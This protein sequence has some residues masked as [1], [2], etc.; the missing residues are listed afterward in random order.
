MQT[1]TILDVWD[2]CVNKGQL[3]KGVILASL[4]FPDKDPSSIMKWSIEKRDAALFHIRKTLFGNQFTNLAHCPQCSQTVEWELSFQQLQIPSILE[5]PDN[6]EIAIDIPAYK[7]LVR[8]PNSNDLLIKDELQILYSCILNRDNYEDQNFETGLPDL[9]V[10][11]INEQFNSSCYASNIT[12]QLN[13]TDC[14]HEWQGIFDILSYLWK[15]IDQWAKGF[16]QQISLLAKAYG[17]SE[18]EI[19]NMSKNRRNHY[20]QLI[21]L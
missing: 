1:N 21:N 9:L 19:I 14:S 2:N 8:L 17:W 12:Y 16:L 5:M 20:L 15:E 7:I 3:Y 4:A 6:V 13:C 11:K 10:Q 18:T